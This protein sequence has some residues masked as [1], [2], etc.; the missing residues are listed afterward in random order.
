VT[1]I[2]V[3][4]DDDHIRAAV[5][6]GLTDRGHIVLGAA[7]GLGALA[8]IVEQRPDVVVLDLGLP[9]IDGLEL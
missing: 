8:D 2:A 9:D 6:R 3:V 7:T 5:S 4:E 1:T